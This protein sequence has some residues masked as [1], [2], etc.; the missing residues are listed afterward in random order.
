VGAYVAYAFDET[1]P[2]GEISTPIL[3]RD[4]STTGAYWLYKVEAVEADRAFS[5]TDVDTLINTAFGDWVQAIKDDPA[6]VI[7]EVELTAEQRTLISEQSKK[8]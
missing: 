7:E 2:V 3:T 1:I 4:S 8:D 6:N 5:E